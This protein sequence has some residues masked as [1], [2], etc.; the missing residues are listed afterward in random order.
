MVE[1]RPG[2]P[3]G[4][5]ARGTEPYLLF[6]GMGKLF[7]QLPT[8]VRH[9]HSTDGGGM[10]TFWQMGEISIISWFFQKKIRSEILK[11]QHVIISDGEPFLW[12]S[13]ERP[14]KWLSRDLSFPFLS[15]FSMA[16]NSLKKIIMCLS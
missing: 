7:Q 12:D 8:L 15:K 6:F 11:L 3:Y 4:G 1:E 16:L 2:A 5:C 10:R 9:L 14:L 13:M